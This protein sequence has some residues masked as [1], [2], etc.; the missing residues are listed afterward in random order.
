M[1]MLTTSSWS[2]WE[3]RLVIGKAFARLHTTCRMRRGGEGLAREMK[4]DRGILAHRIEHYRSRGLGDRLAQDEDAFRLEPV[5]VGQS[6]GHRRGVCPL[7]HNLSL[8]A[9]RKRPRLGWSHRG[10]DQW[11]DS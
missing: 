9:R 10:D 8:A 11:R 7:A 6:A 3:S 2:R 5:E 4:H 1:K